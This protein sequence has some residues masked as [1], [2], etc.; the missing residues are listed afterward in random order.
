MASFS[1]AVNG[2]LANALFDCQSSVL[3]L[4]SSF[5]RVIKHWRQQNGI[6]IAVTTTAGAFSCL[7]NLPPEPVDTIY[8]LQ[9][10]RDWFSYNLGSWCTNI[11]FTWHGACFFFI[12]LFCSAP[13]WKKWVSYGIVSYYTVSFSQATNSISRDVWHF[14]SS[15]YM[16]C[17]HLIQWIEPVLEVGALYNPNL[18]PDYCGDLF[19]HKF[20]NLVQQDIKDTNDDLV[21]PWLIIVEVMCE[22]LR[23]G[24]VV[25]VDTTLVCWHILPSTYERIVRDAMY[26]QDHYK[27]QTLTY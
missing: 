4:S 23:P 12:S 6:P 26:V 13:S 10:E 22:K 5:G 25:I 19:Q 20:A 27:T 1:A 14:R 8:D 11:A 7:V 18:L 2:Y 24:T 3:T 9:L 21:P 17:W 16:W 15:A